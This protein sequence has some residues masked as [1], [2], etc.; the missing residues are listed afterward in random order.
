MNFSGTFACMQVVM[1]T[2]HI[3]NFCLMFFNYIHVY[4]TQ[5]WIHVIDTS[6]YPPII[7]FLPLYFITLICGYVRIFWANKRKRPF[8]TPH[9][10]APSFGK[11]L[12]FFHAL[13]TKT[14]ST[15]VKFMHEGCIF[16]MVYL[17]NK[18]QMKHHFLVSGVIRSGLT[19]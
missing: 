3:N 17:Q 16:S 9:A 6:F 4:K 1:V 12:Y 19:L 7:H 8:F 5:S 14:S 10:F 15:F 18:Q 11:F 2:F 13:A